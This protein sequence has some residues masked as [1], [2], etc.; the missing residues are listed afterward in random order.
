MNSITVIITTYN[1]TL[2]SILSTINSVI[3]QKN[4]EVFLIITDD[5]SKN[6]QE[7]EIKE[8]L[9]RHNFKNYKIISNFENKGTVKNIYATLDYVTS[10]YVKLIGQGDMLYDEYTL[11]KIIRFM[12]INNSDMAFG[13]MVAYTCSPNLEIIERYSPQDL[14]VYINK[15]DNEIIKDFFFFLNAPCGALHV[16]KTSI[17]K[18]YLALFVNRV[19][20]CEDNILGFLLLDNKKIDFYN[21]FLVWYEVGNGISSQNSRDSSKRMRQ[22]LKRSFDCISKERYEF[23]TKRASIFYTIN[24]I[25]N[26]FIRKA[27]KFIFYPRSIFFKIRVKVHKKNNKKIIAID[28]A[29]KTCFY[30]FVYNDGE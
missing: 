26:K 5:G 29:D 3:Y 21:E 2:Q 4:I 7:D 1:G 10:K 23:I 6:F 30:K 15:N 9:K 13:K 20:Y 14:T 12:D 25:N 22:D 8:Y 28:M 24:C 16:Y 18:E 19:R 11:D 17:L 27:I